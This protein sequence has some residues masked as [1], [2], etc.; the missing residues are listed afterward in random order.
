M[1]GNRRMTWRMSMWTQPH[2]VYSCL[3]HFKLQFILDEIIYKTY[4]LSRIN[5]RNLWNNY[6]GQLRS[7]SKITIWLESA[8]VENHL[9][10]V[11]ELFAWKAF[12]LNQIKP[13]KTKIHGDTLSQIIGS[14]WWRTDGIRVDIFPRIRYMGTSRWDSKNGGEI[15]VWTL[16]MSRSIIFMP[17]YND[18]LGN[19]R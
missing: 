13:G 19:T 15:K 8:Y 17:M 2:E 4:D 14:I 11:I 3:S 12:V 7:W 1:I 10:C 18:I 9:C 6:F 5:L 16:A